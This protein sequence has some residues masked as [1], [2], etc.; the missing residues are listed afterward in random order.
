MGVAN[1]QRPH[2]GHDVAP[3]RD[4]DL[5]AQR[6]QHTGQIGDGLLQRKILARD[7]R[8]RPRGQTRQQQGLRVGIEIIHRLDHEHRSGLDR[9]LHR[10]TI[11]RTQDALAILV[12]DV[13]RQ[14][15]LDL[16]RL[17]IAIFRIDDIVLRQPN[18]LSRNRPRIAVHLHEIR[19]A[20]GR[21]GQKV[22][23]R[24]WCRTV[25]F[26][27]NRLIGNDREVIEARFETKPIEKLDLD[28]H[29]LVNRIQNGWAAIVRVFGANDLPGWYG[30][31]GPAFLSV[32]GRG[33]C[34][35][36][37]R[38]IRGISRFP[39]ISAYPSTT[40]SAVR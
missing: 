26:V 15:D 12:R 33:V 29:G 37:D 4:L 24:P 5:H 7:A 40:R 35:S 16:D 2:I 22:V 32:L 17:L 3:G 6:G 25:A 23:E 31:C 8:T 36:K 9:L 34:Q 11:D 18:V 13:G 30:S 38:R 28:F 19:C 14:F 20:Q 21:R 10:A 1:V 39:T 27:A